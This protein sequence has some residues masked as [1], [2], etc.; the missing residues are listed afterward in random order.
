M[1]TLTSLRALK[2]YRDGVKKLF[3][4][5]LFDNKPRKSFP[6]ASKI[7]SLEDQIAD[8]IGAIREKHPMLKSVL[9]TG[10]GFHL[11]YRE[12]EI[13]MRVLERLKSQAVVGLP[14]FDAVIVKA[15]EAAEAKAV[16]ER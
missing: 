15:S 3:N 6:K 10:R 1:G 4:A 5:L 2:H 8:V 13:M 9:S 11:M 12:S 7:L 16:M 14:V